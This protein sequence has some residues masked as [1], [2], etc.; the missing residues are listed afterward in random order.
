MEELL[1]INSKTLLHSR[2]QFL[3]SLA[4]AGGAALL[5]GNVRLLGFIP[6]KQGTIHAIVSDL[7]KCTGCRTCEAVCSAANHRIEVNNQKIP[8]LGNPFLS[9]IQVYGFNPDIDIPLVCAFCPDAPCVASCPVEPDAK[10]GKKALYRDENT[11]AVTCDVQRCIT[12]GSCVATCAEQRTGIIRR[13]PETG[14]PFGMCTLC[15]GDPQCV[16]NCPFD[17]LSMIEVDTSR[18]FFG[19]SPEFIADELNKRWYSIIGEE[20]PHEN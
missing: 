7:N 1:H 12:C 10:T 4:T 16:Q 5:L 9:N 15:D 6:D 20:V 13:H 14:N 17:A 19:K 3:K 2:R 18:E 8:G 11:F